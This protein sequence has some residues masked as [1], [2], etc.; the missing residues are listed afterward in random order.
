MQGHRWVSSFTFFGTNNIISLHYLT[1][2]FSLQLLLNLPD[3]F[4]NLWQGTID[5]DKT[6]DCRNWDWA[7][8][9]GDMWKTHGEAVASTMPYLPGSFY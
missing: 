2:F 3:L 9:K 7:V 1:V 4:L 6:D 5:C 8:L